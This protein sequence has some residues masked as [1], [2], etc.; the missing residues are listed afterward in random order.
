MILR[1]F[2]KLGNLLRPLLTMKNWVCA[3]GFCCEG[4]L[5]IG[6]VDNDEKVASSEKK[7]NMLKGVQKP[8]AG[9]INEKEK[10]SFL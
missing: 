7:K 1:L 4:L 10:S 9:L 2:A 6:L 8:D 5:L 3:K